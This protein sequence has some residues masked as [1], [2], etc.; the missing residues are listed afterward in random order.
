MKIGKRTLRKEDLNENLVS[1]LI[2][3]DAL[4]KFLNNIN[5]KR[6]DPLSAISNYRIEDSILFSFTWDETVEGS[7]YWGDL[8]H[9]FIDYWNE[10]EDS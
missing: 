10:H 5:S 9:K 4:H 6:E 2:E 3:H 7:I 1:F 8:H